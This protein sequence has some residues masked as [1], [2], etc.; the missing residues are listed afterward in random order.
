MRFFYNFFVSFFAGRK[1]IFQNSYLNKSR[2]AAI[3]PKSFQEL[4]YLFPFF[5]SEKSRREPGGRKE[6]PPLRRPYEQR[7]AAGSAARCMRSAPASWLSP[8][9]FPSAATVSCAEGRA[10]DPAPPPPYRSRRE[11]AGDFPALFRLRPRTDREGKP[12]EFLPACPAASDPAPGSLYATLGIIMLN[13]RLKNR[14]LFP[15]LRLR[16]LCR[17][18]FSPAFSPAFCSILRRPGSCFVPPRPFHASREAEREARAAPRC[19]YPCCMCTE[20]AC[21]PAFRSIIFN[22]SKKS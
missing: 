17:A 2:V 5:P 14:F 12:P 3:H 8:W 1:L 6:L 4:Q 16:R 20:R 19:I 22:I 7:K 15:F 10:V 21:P 9:L 11:A 18:Q 13:N